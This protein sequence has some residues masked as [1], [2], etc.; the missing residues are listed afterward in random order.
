MSTFV[1]IV[2]SGSL[3]AAELLDTSLPTVVRTFASLE[4][5]PKTRLLT[6]TTRKITLTEEG[7]S[8]L[9]RCRLFCMKLMMQNWH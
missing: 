9:E 3:T 7:R 2:D 5:H 4:E 6:R 8:Y 1:Q